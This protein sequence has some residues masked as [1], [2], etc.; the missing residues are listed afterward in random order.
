MLQGNSNKYEYEHTR[1]SEKI[2]RRK[3]RT[4][5]RERYSR[6]RLGVQ[7]RDSY[8]NCP[9]GWYAYEL[10]TS[11]SDDS[12]ICSI[13]KKV[14]ANWWG[15]FFTQQELNLPDNYARVVSQNFLG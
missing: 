8:S 9:E 10:R 3:N 13:E 12:Q 5:T 4:N 7:D 14:F 1:V 2:R 11:D 15:C 6:M